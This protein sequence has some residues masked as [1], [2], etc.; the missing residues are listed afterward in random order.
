MK[1]RYMLIVPVGMICLITALILYIYAPKNSITDFLTG[2]FIGLSVA[3]N[4]YAV[5]HQVR[6]FHKNK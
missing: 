5:F 4:I 3:L 6:L 1:L 2:L